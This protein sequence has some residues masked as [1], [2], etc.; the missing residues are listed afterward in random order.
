MINKCNLQQ[1]R[2]AA[3][4]QADSLNYMIKEEGVEVIFS[5][6]HGPDMSGHT[7]MRA[8][9]DRDT[10]RKTEEEIYQCAVGTHEMTDEYIG[11]FLHLLDEGWSILVL[12]N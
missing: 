3:K 8:L 2:Q 10:S 5:H 4:W 6:F 1:W 9:K 11:E 7:Y 12:L